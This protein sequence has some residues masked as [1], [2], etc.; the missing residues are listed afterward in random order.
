MK[1]IVP[2][3]VKLQMDPAEA[4]YRLGQHLRIYYPGT[5]PDKLERS[6][7]PGYWQFKEPCAG[8]GRCASPLHTFLSNADSCRHTIE[9]SEHGTRENG[10]FVKPYRIWE[11]LVKAPVAT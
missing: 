6:L 10:R 9:F 8:A 7:T 1:T 11:A 5:T 4:L 2:V 3:D